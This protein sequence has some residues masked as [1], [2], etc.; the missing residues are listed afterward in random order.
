MQLTSSHIDGNNEDELTKN[1]TPYHMNCCHKQS[2]L[3]TVSAKS[4]HG[5]GK[6]LVPMLPCI[7]YLFIQ[8]I[9]AEGLLCK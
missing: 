4:H 3:S 7:L 6:Y 1:Y 8:E 5:W 9:I 2:L